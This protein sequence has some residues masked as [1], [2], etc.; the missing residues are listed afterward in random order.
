MDLELSG[1]NFLV[2]AASK[3]LGFSVA[4]ELLKEGAN[5]LF[6]SS[7]SA[8]LEHAS[9]LLQSEGLT[10]FKTVKADLSKSE[11]VNRLVEETLSHY[12]G[13]LAGFVTNC[14][15]PPPGLPL[16]ISDEQWQ[17]AFDLVFLSVIRLCRGLVP[18]MIENGGGAI[19]A[20]TSTSVK[21]PISNLTTSN[22]LRPAVAGF[23]KSL[24]NEVAPRNV[25]VNV[26]APG[27]F[28][29]ERTIELDNAASKASGKSHEQVRAEYSAEIPMKRIADVSEFPGLCAF[30]LSKRASYMTGQTICNDGG[31]VAT[32]W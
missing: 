20:I 11:H 14:G 18:S 29:S 30:L 32:I 24:A 10:S 16:Q 8:N 9:E 21:Q 13:K 3:G 19:V 15:G 17:S 31:R 22:S 5:V 23:L 12:D 25:R 26:V 6:S 2:T 27:R 7:R 1:Q 4:R 28:L